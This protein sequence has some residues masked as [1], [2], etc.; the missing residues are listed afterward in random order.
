MDIIVYPVI[1]ISFM[2]SFFMLV[3][4]S[5]NVIT[6]IFGHTLVRVLTNSM[7]KYCP[8]AER[9]FVRGDVVVLKV[10]TLCMKWEM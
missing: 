10:Q 4:K 2:S 8:E 6:P 9:N 3:S 1:L 5:K 7:S